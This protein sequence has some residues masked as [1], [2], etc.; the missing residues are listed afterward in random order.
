M[1][2][3]VE[4]SIE[5]GFILAQY[6]N[7]LIKVSIILIPVFGAFGMFLQKLVTFSR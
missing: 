1:F 4:D 6:Q 7:P 2:V 5:R 3:N